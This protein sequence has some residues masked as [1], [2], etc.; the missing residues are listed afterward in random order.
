MNK[1][2]KHQSVKKAPEKKQQKNVRKV[3]SPKSKNKSNPKI[4][5]ILLNPFVFLGIFLLIL[6]VIG[7]YF[8][9]FKFTLM[10]D[11]GV[12]GILLIS[13]LLSRFKRKKL[14]NI[15]VI[16]I[17]IICIAGVA[18]VGVFFY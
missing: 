17:L 9:D 8:M 11:A 12:I 16:L 13:S 5:S 18:G 10:M 6:T 7:L 2:Q 4:S 15:F 14:V 1:K 3:E